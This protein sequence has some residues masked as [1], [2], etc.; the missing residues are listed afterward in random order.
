MAGGAAGLVWKTS[1]E[2]K[3]D[4][5][6]LELL[7]GVASLQSR[8]EALEESQK[9]ASGR[10]AALDERL[11]ALEPSAKEYPGGRESSGSAGARARA[12][13]TAGEIAEAEG[14]GSSGSGK[15]AG[16]A[17]SPAKQAELD[18]SL[19]T[20]SDAKASW[21]EKETAWSRLRKDGLLDQA[22]AF[23]EERAKES[24]L[25]AGHQ[26]EL[27]SAYIQKIATANDLEK[28]TWALKADK[29]FDSAL[30]LDERHWGARF[31]K[32]AA[33]SFWPPIFGK[34]AEAVKQ[35]EMLKGQQEESPPQEHFAQT[36]LFLGNL[37]QGQ[38]NGEKARE[39]WRKGSELYPD[40]AELRAKA[41][42]GGAVDGK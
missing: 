21:G 23:F 18:E 26:A 40:N 5:C 9:S 6:R 10:V 19:E 8:L 27:G 29:A 22:I 41:A 28:G 39:T 30:A 4:A 36:Y 1:K 12:T 17:L 34:Q 3:S 13:A 35:F 16:K 42:E 32:A 14:V 20:L 25:S 2:R 37:Y 15:S 11:S 24:P 7:A 31:S 33:L 38:G